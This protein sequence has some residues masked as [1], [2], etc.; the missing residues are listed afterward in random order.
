MDPVPPEAV[1]RPC[2]A[3]AAPAD[4]Q[5]PAAD[6]VGTTPPP[7]E[8]AARSLAPAPL[9]PQ[10]EVRLRTDALLRDLW[11]RKLPAVRDQLR[12][13]EQALAMIDADTLTAP[14]RSDAIMAAHKLAGSLGMFGY[15]DGTRF[16]RELEA[17]LDSDQPL[18][19]PAFAGLLRQLLASLNL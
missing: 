12:T 19:R 16:A 4:K 2:A 13:L 14:L 6:G 18:S 10:A 7:G 11:K 15:H 5:T 8:P 17:C 9:A 1:D 3:E